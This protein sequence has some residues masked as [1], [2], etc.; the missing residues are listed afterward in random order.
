VHSENN[1]VKQNYGFFTYRSIIYK[2]S[3]F[4]I[5]L[6]PIRIFFQGRDGDPQYF[7]GKLNPFL[8]ILPFFGFYRLRD[9]P[10]DLKREKKI[11]LAFTLLFFSFVFFT[12]VFRIRYISPIIPP[13]VVLSVFGIKN[14][15][16]FTASRS[17][18]LYYKLGKAFIVVS[19]YQFH[20]IRK[21]KNNMSIYSKLFIRVI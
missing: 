7:D 9:D 5:A 18:R 6:L 10:E 21:T 4:E 8:L 15:F 2:E 14:L 11:M 1:R 12:A 20:L 16:D 17:S 19:L 13:L 3:G